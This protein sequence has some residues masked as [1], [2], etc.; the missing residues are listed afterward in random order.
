MVWEEKKRKGRA[1]FV[2]VRLGGGKRGGR[3]RQKCIDL[4]FA[5]GYTHEQGTLPPQKELRER[6]DIFALYCEPERRRC[7]FVRKL[8]VQM[9]RR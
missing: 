3:G 6:L 2:C 7:L 9:P 1:P 8:L 4:D 5:F